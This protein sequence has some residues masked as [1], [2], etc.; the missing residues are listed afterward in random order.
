MPAARRPS[1]TEGD[2][3]PLADAMYQ[4]GRLYANAGALGSPQAKALVPARRAS[5]QRQPGGLSR[6]LWRQGRE[7]PVR[8]ARPAD[9]AAGHGR[10]GAGG[11][12]EGGASADGCSGGGVATCRGPACCDRAGCGRVRRGAGA[13]SEGRVGA[14]RC[15]AACASAGPC[16]APEAA[17]HDAAPPPRG[18]G[19]RRHADH[20]AGRASP[21]RHAT[22]RAGRARARHHR[23]RGWP[24]TA[25]QASARAP[26]RSKR[27]DRTATR[28]R[29]RQHGDARAATPSSGSAPRSRRTARWQFS[30]K[31]LRRCVRPRCSLLKR[32]V[33]AR[34]GAL[35]VRQ[36]VLLQHELLLPLVELEAVVARLAHQLA[37][38][39]RG[40]GA[41]GATADARGCG[42]A[43]RS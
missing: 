2:P 8:T 35:G 43:P 42:T 26:G 36:P 34:A 17:Q 41:D 39:G 22:H 3:I 24:R 12:R 11:D 20:C 16:V 33:A 37:Q 10:Q 14:G 23:G 40:Q 29:Q 6:A 9:R 21:Q 38:L 5:L 31:K 1:C 25:G 32:D 18:T 4:L 19:P 7:D 30:Q 15:G 27:R 13:D 28:H